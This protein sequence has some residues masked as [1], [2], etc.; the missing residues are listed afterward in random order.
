MKVIEGLLH[1]IINF[2][3]IKDDCYF[4]KIA[5]FRRKYIP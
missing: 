4:K 1:E 5:L 3:I 2:I